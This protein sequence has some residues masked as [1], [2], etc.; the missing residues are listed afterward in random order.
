ML[1]YI[2]CSYRGGDRC[3]INTVS[4]KSILK[5]I[6]VLY[7]TNVSTVEKDISSISSIYTLS[8]NRQLWLFIRSMFLLLRSQV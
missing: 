5:T 4:A 3:S 6:V 1:L 7:M 8:V 2:L